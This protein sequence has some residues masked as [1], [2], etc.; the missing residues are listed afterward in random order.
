MHW[1][2][3]PYKVHSKYIFISMCIFYE[4]NQIC[5]YRRHDRSNNKKLHPNL[6]NDLQWPL[7]MLYMLSLL[8]ITNQ[9]RTFRIKFCFLWPDL[10]WPKCSISIINSFNYP[11]LIYHLL[12][13]IPK[14]C[15][16]ATNHQLQICHFCFHGTWKINKGHEKWWFNEAQVT[17]VEFP[18]HSLDSY[19]VRHHSQSHA[20]KNTVITIQYFAIMMCTIRKI[21]FQM[22]FIIFNL[23]PLCCRTVFVYFPCKGWIA[24]PINRS[25]DWQLSRW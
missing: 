24:Y 21:T 23:W 2:K 7:I 22:L 18:V 5:Y 12:N 19:F 9:S 14:I 17:S 20:Q 3:A 11:K 8:L 16:H 25:H 13:S 1:Y 10:S 4:W 15:W 6:P